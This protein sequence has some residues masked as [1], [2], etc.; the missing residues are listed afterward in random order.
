MRAAGFL[1]V[2]EGNMNIESKLSGHWTD[3]QLIGHIYGIGPADGHLEQCSKCKERLSAMQ[4][5]RQIV[6]T[7]SSD[8]Y[9]KDIHFW[10]AQRR[11]VYERLS[12]PEPWWSQGTIRRWASA[13]ATILV[14]AGGVFF[15]Q[16]NQKKHWTENQ[17]SDVQLAQEVSSMSQDSGSPATAPLEALFEE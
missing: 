10:A 15:Y 16:E 9:E 1:R 11:N 3:E 4:R 6:E 17:I 7:A 8:L 12:R 5:R 13:A 2:A 14:L